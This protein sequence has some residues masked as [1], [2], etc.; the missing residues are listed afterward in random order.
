MRATKPNQKWLNDKQVAEHIGT[1]TQT[2]WNWDQDPDLAFPPA[3]K[4]GRLKLRNLDDVEAWLRTHT[5]RRL[6]PS[7]HKEGQR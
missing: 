7:E 2:L 4:I 3:V 6:A 1:T 5:V